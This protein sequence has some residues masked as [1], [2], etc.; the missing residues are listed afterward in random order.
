MLQCLVLRLRSPYIQCTSF[1]KNSLEVCFPS[2]EPP[3]SSLSKWSFLRGLISSI[4]SVCR[5]VPFPATSCCFAGLS[6][7][8]WANTSTPTHP[9][10]NSYFTLCSASCGLSSCLS[11]YFTA[12]SSSSARPSFV[13]DIS[14]SPCACSSSDLRLCRLRKTQSIV[15]R[16]TILKR[17]LLLP[18][19]CQSWLLWTILKV[20]PG[21]MRL[22]PSMKSAITVQMSMSRSPALS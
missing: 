1:N 3:H 11:S 21:S 22:S 19:Q 7:L 10:F 4:L 6:L 13:Q 18:L 14:L 9:P 20:E 17:Q 5:S 8:F 16:R 12:L 2:S 15:A